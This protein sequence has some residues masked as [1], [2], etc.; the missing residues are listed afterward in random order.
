VLIS[1]SSLPPIITLTICRCLSLNTRRISPTSKKLFSNNL[2]PHPSTF[3]SANYS[4]SISLKPSFH[5]S[6]PH[7]TFLSSS[8]FPNFNSPVSFYRPSSIP[9]TSFY[10]INSASHKIYSKN[11]EGRDVENEDNDFICG[12]SSCF[13]NF[14]LVNDYLF[15]KSTSSFPVPLTSSSSIFHF[16]LPSLPNAANLLLAFIF[17]FFFFCLFNIFV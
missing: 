9:L 15:S 1:S 17:F 16:L 3:P 10:L 14:N 2:L 8:L 6:E 4:T 13:L 5:I 7:L 11:H 12:D